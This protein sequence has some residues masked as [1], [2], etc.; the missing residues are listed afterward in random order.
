M[1]HMKTPIAAFILLHHATVAIA[2]STLEEVVV[3]AT[4]RAESTQ[5]IA[6]SVSAI[7]GDDLKARGATEFFDYA[8]TIP[9]L[10]FGAATDGVLSNRSISLRG[11]QGRNTTGF[12]IDDTPISETIDPR[13]LELERIEVLRGPSGTLYGG[14]SLGGTIRQITKAP[15]FDNLSGN[16][17]AS[18]SST[19]ESDDLNHQLYGSINLPFSEQAAGIFSIL[20]EQEAGVFDR[21]VGEISNHLNSPATLNGPAGT[22]LNDVD[23]KDTLALQASLLF[24]PSDALS[25]APRIMY[26]KT[27]LDGF[28]L[29]D[30]QPGNFQQNRDFNSEEGGEDEWKLVNLNVN[31]QTAAGTFTSASSY[32]E[33]DTFEFEDSASFINFLQ[34][35][36]SSAGGFGLFDVIGVRPVPSPIFQTLSFESTTQELRFSSEL[37]GAINFVIGAFYQN[38]EEL[39]AFQ[40]RNFA[41]GLGNNF[42]LLQETLG[43]P[44]PLEAIWPFGDLV[45]TS[46]RPSEVT[47]K[48][49]FGEMNYDV[50]DKLSVIL[51]ARWYDTEVNFSETQAGLAAGVPLANDQNLNTVEATVGSQNEDGF[52]FKAAIEYQATDDL[53]YYASVAE[54]FRIGGA[55]GS[56]PNSLGCPEDL[57]ELGLAGTDT[58]SFN[59][60]D[61]TSYEA[62]MKADLNDFNR[63]NATLFYIDFQGIQQSVQLACGFQFIGNFGAA[64]SMG[65]ELEYTVQASDELQFILNAGYTDA[66]F[67]ETLAGINQKGDPLQFV[68]D[69]TAALSADYYQADAFDGWDFFL[70]ADVSYVGE[71][72]SRVNSATRVR[73][74]YEQIN[75]RVGIRDERYRL[76][77]FAN[78]LSNEIANLADNRSLAAETP[79]RPR[80]VVS[81]PRTLGLEFA[82]EF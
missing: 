7:S 79:G 16:L 10:S 73:D 59:S 49:V 62:G 23:S 26:Q 20:Y 82:L 56:I 8:N 3:T 38:T 68:P 31:Y 61:L 17:K 74:A 29:A 77:L 41:T 18:L 33:R 15:E 75:L 11:I 27:E 80:F 48:G 69:I 67:T 19:D 51:G 30:I 5:S 12:Y 2:E 70:R 37:D 14:R 76:T 60:D 58:S 39:E 6:L 45:F 63:L 36:P 4:K 32:F 46:S 13:I 40:P 53:F 44:G 78:N 43:I 42:A 25:I 55:N 1:K 71:S 54:G 64:R 57:Q 35:L 66:E 28:P 9:N 81:R 21:H 72:T 47:E 34:A 24:E 50:N 52:I 22:T 65:A